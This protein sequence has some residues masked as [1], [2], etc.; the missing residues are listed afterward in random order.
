MPKVQRTSK[1]R[2]ST[3]TW[4]SV[5]SKEPKTDGL[6]IDT[7]DAELKSRGQRK[8]QAKREQYLRKERMVMSSLKLKHEEEQKNRI[9]GL[10][11]IKEALLATV[12]KKPRHGED[13]EPAAHKPNLLKSNKSRKMLLQKEV[14]QM[15]LVLQHPTFNEDPFATIREHL[16]NTLANDT[17][18]HDKEAAK[19]LKERTKK[20]EE[21]K[22]HRKEQGIKKKRKKRFKATRSK[23]R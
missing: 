22:A 11:A 16:T 18:K 21:K 1:F 17:K 2:R 13:D 14:T 7:A 8:R 15:N 5:P 20:E 3:A 10:D 19:H 4:A 23:T 9:D 6:S 12:A